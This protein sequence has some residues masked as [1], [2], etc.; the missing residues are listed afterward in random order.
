V[1]H[2]AR[3]ERFEDVIIAP[4]FMIGHDVGHASN[5]EGRMQNVET[6]TASFNRTNEAGNFVKPTIPAE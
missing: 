1:Q 2:D 3:L 4:G 6:K 5:V